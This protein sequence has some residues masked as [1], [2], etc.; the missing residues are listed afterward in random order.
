MRFPL[1]ALGFV[2][3]GFI[4]LAFFAFGSLLITEVDDA[5]ESSVDNLDA[6]SKAEVNGYITLV[7][8]AFGVIAAIFFV[9]GIILIFVLESLS[10]E[11]EYF[12]RGPYR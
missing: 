4:F 9:T 11:P 5:L 1:A 6:A 10:E 12:N 7:T 8:N 3:A 2:V